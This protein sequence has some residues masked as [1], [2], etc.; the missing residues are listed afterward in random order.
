MEQL[1]YWFQKFLN[2][3]SDNQLTIDKST[4][5]TLVIGQITIYG[6]LLTFYQ[7]VVSYHGNKNVSDRYLGVNITEYFVKKKVSIFDKIVSKKCFIAIFLLEIIYLPFITIYKNMIPHKVISIMNFIWFAIVIVYFVIFVML[8]SQC[9]RTLMK[10]KMSSDAKTNGYIVQKI[11]ENFLKK[12]LSRRRKYNKVELLRQDFMCLHNQIQIDNNNQLQERYNELICFVFDEYSRKKEYEIKLIENKKIVLNN[13]KPWIYNAKEEIYLIQEFIDEKYFQLDKKN[14]VD[15]FY[16]QI[17]LLKLNLNRAKIDGYNEICVNRIERCSRKNVFNLCEWFDTTIEIY[18]KLDDKGKQRI[19]HALYYDTNFSQDSFDLYCRKCINTLIASEVENVF[20]G[21][22]SQKA[23]CEIFRIIIKDDYFNDYYTEIIKDQ[24]ISYD[25][26]DAEKMLELLNNQNCTYLFI[27][28]FL[29][30]SIYTFRF[31]WKFFNIK[32]LRMLWNRHS[33]MT[34]VENIVINKI[35]S[36]NIGHRFQE[37]IYFDFVEFITSGE[38]NFVFSNSYDR[39][40]LDEFYKWVIKLC[41][42]NQYDMIHFA[43]QQNFDLNTQ[44]LIVN[45]LTKH[46]ELLQCKNVIDWIECVRYNSFANIDRVPSKLNV[47][48]RCLLLI[49][50]DVAIV[51]GDLYSNYNYYNSS[52]GMYILIKLCDLS[53]KKKKQKHIRRTVVNAFMA[54]NLDID[55][56]LD[57]IIKECCICNF[58]INDMQKEKMKEY[59]ISSI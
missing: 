17:N 47:S 45:E 57:M 59:L 9:T 8:F 54:S 24:V 23:F 14:I 28:I 15:I 55:K 35:K 49:N 40:K 34:E 43:D 39:I 26:F 16:F 27:Y 22:M 37:K 18:K 1:Y 3:I 25:K 12:S 36:S 50:I 30:Y 19:I 7:F 48:L 2:Y 29:Y 11:N 38:D 10:L 44:I 13:Q 42:I 32:M 33:N 31:E 21:R 46:D 41:V 56:Y 58:K 52:V 53:S 20:K 51:I 5:F 4:F 6:I